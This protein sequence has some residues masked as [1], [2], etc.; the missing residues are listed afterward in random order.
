MAVPRDALGRSESLRLKS[1]R[2][3][4]SRKGGAILVLEVN[5][6]SRGWGGYPGFPSYQALTC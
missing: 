5:R 6:G 2:G 1:Q 4:S 3:G